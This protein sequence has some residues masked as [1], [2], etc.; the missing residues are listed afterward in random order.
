VSYTVTVTNHGPG[1]ATG[2][3]VEHLL[4]PDITLAGTPTAKNPGH[5]YGCA[6]YEDQHRVSCDS[7]LLPNR[8]TWTIT[9]NVRAGAAGTLSPRVVVSGAEPDPHPD[10][11]STSA[12]TTVHA[13]R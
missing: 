8:G 9:L 12:R 11:D 10:N 6:V 13:P 1:D 2:L 5:G 7:W 3:K 4:P